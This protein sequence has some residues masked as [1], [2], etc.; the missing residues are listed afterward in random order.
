MAN[1]PSRELILDMDKADKLHWT[2]NSWEQGNSPDCL[3]SPARQ[4]VT[5][6]HYCDKEVQVQRAAAIAKSSHE[7]GGTT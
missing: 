5:A 4:A 7:A 2:A 1:S 6:V 3:L